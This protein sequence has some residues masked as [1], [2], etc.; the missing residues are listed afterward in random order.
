VKIQ[1]ELARRN[2]ELPAAAQVR[3]RVGV[4]LGDAEER[5]GD[6]FEDG[7]ESAAG[8]AALAEPG[9]ICISRAVYDEVRFRLNLSYDARK[10]LASFMNPQQHVHHAPKVNLLE[11]SAVRISPASIVD[12]GV[13]PTAYGHQKYAGLIIPALVVGMFS[14]IHLITILVHKAGLPLPNSI[15][16][17]VPILLWTIAISAFAWMIFHSK[18]DEGG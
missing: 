6:R 2:R 7:V 1:Q 11:A 9:G 15:A 17:G 3:G 16:A 4:S 18:K 10:T 5:D 13:A 14:G 8:L 12:Q